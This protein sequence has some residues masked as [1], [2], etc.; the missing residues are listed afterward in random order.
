MKIYWE[1][2]ATFL[3]LGL[4]T[5]GGGFSMLPM[6]ERELVDRRGWITLDELVNYYAISQSIPGIIMVNTALFVGH[7]KKGV[8][9]SLV[10]LLG[11]LTPS[12][13]IILLIA[14]ALQEYSHVAMVQH[15]FA[16]VRTALCALIVS[17]VI[18]LF[19]NSVLKQ[20]EGVKRSIGEVFKQCWLQMLLCVVAF[21]L[22]AIANVSPVFIVLGAALTGLVAMRRTE[23]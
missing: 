2:L 11:I 15:A 4:V 23:A 6:Y 14:T 1:I 21:V 16:G 18:R 20:K 5:F 19:R 22:I 8:R 17:A 9:G 10:A 12:I 7:R 3:R 13:V